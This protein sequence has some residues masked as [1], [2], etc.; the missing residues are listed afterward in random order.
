MGKVQKLIDEQ[1]VD[2]KAL[3]YNYTV[4][5]IAGVIL[6]LFLFITS[7][8][9]S[10]KYPA[11][12]HT[13]T[14][15]SIF[16]V[17]VFISETF[18][19]KKNEPKRW[20]LLGIFYGLSL[21]IAV[22]IDVL[23]YHMDSFYIK[24]VYWINTYLSLTVV[25][26][27]GMCLYK[28]IKKNN[29]S[30]EKYFARVIFGLLKIWAVFL[31]L[32]FATVL[33]LEMFDS[34]IMEIEYWRA[35]EKVE[36]L[37]AGFV[38]FPYSLMVVTDTSEDNSK[39]TK[40]LFA[41][42]LMPCVF[43]A[44]IIMYMY[45]I[46]MIINFKLPSN[47]VFLICAEY[48]LLGAPI[49]LITSA[50][51]KDKA[52]KNGEKIGIYGKIVGNMAYIFSPCIILEIICIGI[53]IGEYGLTE[54]RYGAVCFIILQII[55]VLWKPLMKL[56]KKD[57]GYEGLISVVIIMFFIIAITPVINIKRACYLSQKSIFEEGLEEGDMEAVEG[58][59]R[60]LESTFY[61][62]EYLRENY[63]EK[64]EEA[65]VQAIYDA[66]SDEYGPGYTDYYE[67]EDNV[68]TVSTN[69]I[70]ENG[71]DISG[72]STMR[73]F[74]FYE[75]NKIEYEDK[76]IL[77]VRLKGSDEET[78]EDVDFTECINYYL[79]EEHREKVADA[80]PYIIEYDENTSLVVYDIDFT[81]N[82]YGKYIRCIDIK[83]YVLY[84]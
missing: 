52:E 18:I 61:G 45:M 53:R 60:F 9:N 23:E 77:D 50:F 67:Y 56:L 35:M 42:A 80:K 5:L 69:Y 20:G 29:I 21:I 31:L 84:K 65:L 64:E 39:F 15:M 70:N 30:I 47:E 73:T 43:V 78:I 4:T 37:L 59:Y 58:A 34:L 32:N 44:T 27:L 6:S 63:T 24:T 46:S 75:Y 51:L 41:F 13:I 10:Y 17:G 12:G 76:I 79:H 19:V 36:I 2:L 66:N 8:M 26:L 74:S 48:F 28:L 71:L 1:K 62:K 33:I 55:Y 72:Y 81:I 82:E 83:G 16:L 3:V 49:W 54:P 22:I 11:I 38:Y 25:T 57:I 40:G 68:Y 7:Y 14:I